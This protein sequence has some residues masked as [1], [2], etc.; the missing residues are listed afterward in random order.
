MLI[1][2][3]HHEMFLV[4]QEKLI[5][6]IVATIL[7]TFREI[8]TL[9][10]IVWISYYLLS[11][12][13]MEM[14]LG[15]GCVRF[16]LEWDGEGE[17]YCANQPLFAGKVFCQWA[18]RE[19]EYSYRKCQ[20]GV[21][22]TEIGIKSKHSVVQSFKLLLNLWTCIHLWSCLEPL[23]LSHEI[24]CKLLIIVLTKPTVQAVA[25]FQKWVFCSQG[26]ILQGEN[27]YS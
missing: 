9:V 2:H 15:R 6:W 23:W 26:I 12:N 8:V 4:V 22:F 14:T 16:V 24:H 20:D 10:K 18:L 27:L 25:E 7:S 1:T 19:A 11:A 21:Y 3:P 5:N 13:R 17:Y